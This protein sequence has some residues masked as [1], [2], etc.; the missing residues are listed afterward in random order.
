M[1]TK[2]SHTLNALIYPAQDVA[3]DEWIA[4]CLELDLVTQGTGQNGA[5]EMLA[6]AIE[7]VAKENARQGRFPLQFRAAPKEDWDRLRGAEQLC[8]RM[9]NLPVA[10]EL[11][12]DVTIVSSVASAR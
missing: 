9:L 5:L 3:G 4:H 2:L 1:S 6:E 10:R 8:T 7:A 12:D 11:T